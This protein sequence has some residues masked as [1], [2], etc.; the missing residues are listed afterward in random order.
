MCHPYWRFELKAP[1]GSA[2]L[3]PDVLASS[4]TPF[5][6][7]Q[8]LEWGIS[9]FRSE[10]SC[11]RCPSLDY[12][13][14]R[15][16][17]AGVKS[18]QL[19]CGNEET[20]GVAS[21]GCLP[22]AFLVSPPVSCREVPLFGSEKLSICCTVYFCFLTIDTLW[23]AVVPGYRLHL[24]SERSS[25]KVETWVTEGVWGVLHHVLCAGDFIVLFSPAQ[26]LHCIFPGDVTWVAWLMTKHCTLWVLRAPA[27]LL[28]PSTGTDL[29]P[30]FQWPSP[31][32][33]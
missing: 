19:D 25:V 22:Y 12:Q 27:W 1:G 4:H 33:T 18:I 8:G 28:S 20:K 11:W 10:R 21:L 14:S 2:S 13:Q 16:P 3:Q 31:V 30:S 7:L 32:V 5:G 29:A 6:L 17:R 24:E 15:S 9:C 23:G 26:C